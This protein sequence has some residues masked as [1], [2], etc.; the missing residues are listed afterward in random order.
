MVC[1]YCY[2]TD[3]VNTSAGSAARVCKFGRGEVLVV[4][5]LVITFAAALRLN[6]D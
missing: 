2:F 4:A 3:D 1:F 6:L 5:V